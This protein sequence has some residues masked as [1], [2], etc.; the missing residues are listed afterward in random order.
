MNSSSEQLIQEALLDEQHPRSTYDMV[1]PGEVRANPN[2]SRDEKYFYSIV[3]NLARRE[4]Y[5]WATNA[6]LEKELE[7]CER[8]IRNWLSRLKEEGYIEIE[9][10]SYKMMNRRRIWITSSYGFKNLLIRKG[11]SGPSGKKFPDDTEPGCLHTEERVNTKEKEVVCYP[12]LVGSGSEKISVDEEKKNKAVE[13]TITKT[14]VDGHPVEVKQQDI[15]YA[16]LK[17]KKDWKTSEIQEAWEILLLYSGPIRDAVAFIEGTIRNLRNKEKSTY[18]AKKGKET[19]KT[20]E[21]NIPSR[22]NEKSLGKDTK[23]H[24]SLQFLLEQA[25]LA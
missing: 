24:P 6:Y 12:N 14:H 15:F 7:V 5:C 10:I 17:N 18:L 3:R 22:C 23:E 13:Y 8:T 16:S 2:L 4:G 20:Q 11:D 25:G 21:T 9:Q 19:C 1:I